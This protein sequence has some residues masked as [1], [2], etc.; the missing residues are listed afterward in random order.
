[1]LANMPHESR[2]NANAFRQVIY[3]ARDS[4]ISYMSGDYR[5]VDDFDDIVS[6]EWAIY[7]VIGKHW[8]LTMT[9]DDLFKPCQYRIVNSHNGYHSEWLL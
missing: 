4:I 9:I 1:M 6:A 7:D 2:R 3:S 8:D 5:L